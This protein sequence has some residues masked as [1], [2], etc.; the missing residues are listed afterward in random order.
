M[1]AVRVHSPL[2]DQAHAAARLSP[3]PAP[4][5]YIS[6]WRLSRIYALNRGRG[7][8]TVFKLHRIN[9]LINRESSPDE[10]RFKWAYEYLG[11][12]TRFSSSTLHHTHPPAPIMQ[13]PYSPEL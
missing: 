4:E 13:Q 12:S 11:C 9:L 10:A 5:S 2:T 7:G 3:P 8:R 6:P 1:L